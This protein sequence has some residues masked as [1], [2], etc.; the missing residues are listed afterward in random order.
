MNL[1]KSYKKAILNLIVIILLIS[2]PVLAKMHSG[3]SDVPKGHWAYDAIQNMSENGIFQGTDID[4]KTNET[5]FSPDEV[6]TRAEFV[7]ALTRYLYPSELDKL[8]KIPGVEWFQPNYVLA[9]EKGLLLSSEFE[10]GDLNKPCSREEMSML[11]VRAAEKGMGET[12]YRLLPETSIYDY[13]DIDLY[14]K[15]YVRKAYSMGLLAG[16]DAKGTFAPD[17]ILNRAQAATV[18]YR[19][20]EPSS[21]D[22]VF[23][24]QVV[25]YDWDNGIH[26]EGEYL[27]G[28]ANGHGRMTFPDEGTYIGYFTDGNR[29]GIGTFEW[30]VGDKYVGNWSDD[31]MNG[32][33]IYTFADGYE[34]KGFW[35][36]N[37][38]KATGLN[39]TIPTTEII[40]GQEIDVVALLEPI[41]ATEIIEWK[42]SNEKVLTVSSENN[43][44]KIKGISAGTAKVTAKTSTETKNCE[45]TVKKGSI[46]VT[47]VALSH[48][49][50]TSEV[51]KTFTLSAT[52][53]PSNAN[54]KIKWSSSNTKVASV[55]SSGRVKCLKAGEA[56]ISAA[57]ENG[58]LATCYVTVTDNSKELWDGHWY[59]YEANAA[60]KREDSYLWSYDECDIDYDNMTF[61]LDSYP[62][63][64]IGEVD[65]DKDNHYTLS[66][67]VS[68]YDDYEI[69]F[70]SISENMIILEINEITSYTYSEDNVD[71]TYY[72]LYRVKQ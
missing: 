59:V 70:T 52:Y 30:Y 62:F 5:K 63:S 19:L 36:D 29:D 33:G 50:Y 1:L 72:V 15:D 18:M 2:N 47:Q 71:T 13:N 24:N 37:Q 58:L 42:S 68:R 20:I 54:N 41:N 16:I 65:L 12:P 46:P 11:L 39:F 49:D 51:D 25:T 9:C 38:I 56:I 34:I 57:A 66:A 69:T 8:E 67:E 45:V 23:Q 40:I 7:T 61:E 10:N 26:Y 6:M 48:G 27:N 14:Y 43:T 60:G 31:K 22:I 44:C 21:R 64:M 17:D 35:E 3:Y 55:N 28:Q 4:P 53:L 32:Y